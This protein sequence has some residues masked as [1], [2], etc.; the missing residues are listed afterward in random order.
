[1][2]HTSADWELLYSFISQCS[3][4]QSN[5]ICVNNSS[6][7]KVKQEWPLVCYICEPWNHIQTSAG[8]SEYH[9]YM[10][11]PFSL[12]RK[13]L[14]P[15]AHA[16]SRFWLVSMS[17]QVAPLWRII[18]SN[19]MYSFVNLLAYYLHMLK[20]VRYHPRVMQYFTQRR[21]TAILFPLLNSAIGSTAVQF[22]L[23]G[24]PWCLH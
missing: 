17:I 2:T 22:R 6:Y 10:V 19:K 11:E 1:M 24:L 4:R 8:A 9:W 15:A 14:T 12:C 20:Y 18:M 5:H 3:S 16:H 21:F 7:Q 23:V 13:L